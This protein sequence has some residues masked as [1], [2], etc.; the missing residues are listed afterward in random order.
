MSFITNLKASIRGK[1]HQLLLVTILLVIIVSPFTTH[2]SSLGWLDS[3]VLMP[4]L[5]T[6]ASTVSRRGRYFHVALFLGIPA[7][8]AQISVFTIDNFW[9]TTLKYTATPLFLFWVSILLLWDIALRVHTVTLN[10]ILGAINVYLM[11]GI[12]FALVFTLIE[13]LLPGSFTGLEGLV[14]M[15]DQVSGFVY[16]SFITM[17]TLGYGDISPVKPHAMTASYLLAIIGQLYLA[18]FVARL[19][20]LYMTQPE[21]TGQ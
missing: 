11:L 1:G 2:Y 3:I 7:F 4:V 19:V 18:I 6:A 8:I 16:Y 5:L 9:L 17:T 20:S 13:N 15:P 12:G 14:I 21:N 10:L